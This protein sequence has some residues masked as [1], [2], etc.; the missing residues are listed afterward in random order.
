MVRKTDA[1]KRRRRLEWLFRILTF[2]VS[3]LLTLIVIEIVLR[4]AWPQIFLPHPPGIYSPD[5]DIGFVLTPSFKGEFRGAEFHVSVKINKSGLRGKELRPLAKNSVRILCLG[6]SF[7]WGWGTNDNE[8]YPAVM[9]GF[10][11]K[12]YPLLD[13]QVLNA[14]VAA[15]GTDEELEFLKKQGEHLKPNLVIVQF[16]AGN[17]F[18]D[19]ILPANRSYEIRDG[20]LYQINNAEEGKKPVWLSIVNWLK[21]KSHL[22]H[23]V[24]E[25]IGYLAMRAGLLTELERSSSKYFTEADGERATDL[26]VKIANVAGQLGAKTLFVFVPD[27]PQ[28]LSRPIEPLRAATTVQAAA[29]ITN[30]P[31]IDLTPELVKRIDNEDV[32]FAQDAHWTPKGHEWVAQVLTE[33]ICDLGLLDVANTQ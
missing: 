31:W 26:L 20:M 17:D 19:N 10:L 29:E 6:D 12:R 24:S 33:Q 11:Q 23:L 15:Y 13:V 16:F 18:D 30:A 21:Q 32:Y 2:S 1:Q 25:R 4:F 9:E 27:K 5:E 28:I 22:F 7:T 3:L 14:G 8:A